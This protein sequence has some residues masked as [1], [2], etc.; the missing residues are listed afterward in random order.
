QV[1]GPQSPVATLVDADS[2]WVQ[3]AIPVEELA[4]IDV[5]GLGKASGSKARV[6]QETG[7]AKPSERTGRVV[8]LLGDL[9]PVGRMA[10]VLVEVDDPLETKDG[11][12]PL[13]LG[14]YV[15]VE[16]LGHPIEGVWPIP[17]EALRD[18]DTVYVMDAGGKLDIR[19][20]KVVRRT[21]GI[22]AV[23][24]D[25]EKGESLVTS[26]V[27]TPVQGMDLRTGDEAD[28]ATRAKGAKTGE[29]AQ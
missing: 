20:V 5:P 29:V 3:V 17:R 27:D 12:L 25:L 8:R 11:R 28:V 21:D 14:S 22:V 2:F 9:D 19:K 15:S 4:W 18:G 26:R 23:R 6:L 24:G 7:T 1:V 10:R 13:L 16:I